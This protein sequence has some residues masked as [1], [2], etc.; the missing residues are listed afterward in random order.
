[1]RDPV[2]LI[3]ED[4]PSTR[5]CLSEILKTEG[6]AVVTATDG[7]AA[8]EHLRRGVFPSVIV[9]NLNMPKMN[10]WQF[11]KELLDDPIFRDI[12]TVVISATDI[13]ELTAQTRLDSGRHF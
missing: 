6:F 11:R 1:V 3:V 2:V 7:L 13:A 9:T 8:L 12:P 5:E 10:G 4:D